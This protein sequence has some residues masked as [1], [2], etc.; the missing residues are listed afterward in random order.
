MDR[1]GE[2]DL[3]DLLLVAGE[4]GAVDD[5]GAFRAAVLGQLRRLVPCDSASYN[6]VSPHSPQ[7]VVAAVDPHETIFDG[8][9]ELFATFIHQNPLVGAAVRSG[10]DEVRK[11]SDFITARQLH[12]LDLYDHVYSRLEVEH[13]IA[14][15]LVSRS[16]QLIG[17]ALNRRSQDFSERDRSVLEAVQPFVVHAYD[18]AL[19]R[20]VA[21]QSV[22]ALEAGHGGSAQA[23]LVLDTHGYVEVASDLAATWCRGLAPFGA[24][25]RLPEPLRSWSDTQRARA[26]GGR[27]L[28]QTLEVP[29]P[30]AVLI[31]RY[32]AGT[33]RQADAILL[34]RRVIRDPDAGRRLGLTAR[35][36]EVLHLVGQGLSN[37]QV[38]RDLHLSD[39][40]VAKHLERAY[41][42]LGV[43][44]RTAALARLRQVD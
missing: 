8:A 37:L 11:F 22:A 42:K 7:A 30:G 43:T 18:N 34:S 27:S 41:T 26:R 4:L 20:T 23:I 19:L 3:K 10:T 1:L 14:L 31:A 17:L 13:Q 5:V 39:R 16:H 33:D 44:S 21:R 29:V 12:R 38:A 32:V 25:G 35:E 15:T 9:T 24:T 40:T 28:T 36:S 6:E 2:T